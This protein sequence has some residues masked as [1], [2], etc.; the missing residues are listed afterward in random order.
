MEWLKPGE[1]AEAVQ[2]DDDL[3]L[4]RLD[5]QDKGLSGDWG[6]PGAPRVQVS[7]VYGPRGGH[8]PHPP[9][10]VPIGWTRGRRGC[11]I[12]WCLDFLETP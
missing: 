3:S 9:A 11:V 1:D 10:V 5:L 8:V 7:S 6:A 4:D 12:L 2:L